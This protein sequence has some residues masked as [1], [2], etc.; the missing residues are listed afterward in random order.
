MLGCLDDSVFPDAPAGPP[1]EVCRQGEVAPDV[2]KAVAPGSSW[3]TGECAP[4]AG[5]L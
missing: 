4:V 2:G 1:R 5:G 3:N